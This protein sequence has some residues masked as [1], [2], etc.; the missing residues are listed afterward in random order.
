MAKQGAGPAADMAQ[1]E[2]DLAA[3]TAKQEADLA[4][5]PADM[6]D[7]W[8]EQLVKVGDNQAGAAESI[9]DPE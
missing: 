9:T 1:R 4:A 2:V 3:H 6:A 7:N 8:V 5:L